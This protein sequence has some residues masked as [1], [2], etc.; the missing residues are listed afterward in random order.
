MA[1][2]QRQL[3][4]FIKPDES[5]AQAIVHVMVVVCHFIGHIGQ[6]R[7]ERRLL[8]VQEA[9]PKFPKRCRITCTAMLQNSLTRLEG[10]VQAGKSRVFF[11]QLV[12]HSQTLQVVLEATIVAHT[13]VQGVLTGMPEWRMPQVVCQRNGFAQRL[14]QAEYPRNGTGHLRYLQ[15]MRQARAVEVAFVV[16]EDL[17]LVDQPTES[18]AMNNAIAV[19][20]IFSAEPRRRFAV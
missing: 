8:P 20:L 15:R 7:L 16:H 9:A 2:E 12:D 6:L 11:L 1:A 18:T 14:V 3:V 13:I 5:G 19:T 17:R 4:Q 10:E